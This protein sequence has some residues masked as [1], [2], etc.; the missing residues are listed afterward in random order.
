MTFFLRAAVLCAIFMQAASAADGLAVE[1][2]ETESS[3]SVACQTLAMLSTPGG[4]G[5]RADRKP[6]PNRPPRGKGRP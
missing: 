4:V 1:K 6:A 3:A 5:N 2:V